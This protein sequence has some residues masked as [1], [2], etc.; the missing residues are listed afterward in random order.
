MLLPF[1]NGS[2][3]ALKTSA[4]AYTNIGSMQKYTS[5]SNTQPIWKLDMDLYLRINLTQ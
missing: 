1:L 2:V 4:V 5:L 3:A